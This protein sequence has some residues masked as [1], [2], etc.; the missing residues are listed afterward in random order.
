MLMQFL[1]MASKLGEY[2][3]LAM[4]HY[5]VLK[6]SGAAANPEVL[7]FFLREKL[8]TWDPKIG[9]NSLLD[10]ATRDAAARFLAGV[11]INMSGAK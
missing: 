1:P 7:A 5:A 11:A 8:S 10:D 6:T 3:K 9:K 2:L 4:D